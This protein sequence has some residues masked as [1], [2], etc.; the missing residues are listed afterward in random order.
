MISPDGRWLA[1]FSN[2]SGHDEVYVRPFPEPGGHW[3]ASTGYGTNPGLVAEKFP[4]LFYRG[5]EG[6][7]GFFR[8]AYWAI[9]LNT[10]PSRVGIVTE[11]S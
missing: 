8:N 4:E 11:D 1:Y 7:T 10:L 2:E 6:I 9:P 3:P 5:N